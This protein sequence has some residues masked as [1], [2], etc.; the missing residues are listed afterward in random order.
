M[1]S[2]IHNLILISY[3]KNPKFIIVFIQ[4]IYFCSWKYYSMSFFPSFSLENNNLVLVFH[5]PSS[6]EMPC[7]FEFST[8]FRLPQSDNATHPFFQLPVLPTSILHVHHHQLFFPKYNFYQVILFEKSIKA[9]QCLQHKIYLVW[10]DLLNPKLLKIL[11]IFLLFSL[12]PSLCS[13]PGLLSPRHHKIL[14]LLPTIYTYS[15]IS[16]FFHMY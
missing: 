15:S 5:T 12:G 16:Y 2:R 11:T 9:L 13:S 8:S 3:K 6:K 14:V 4:V 1:I 10:K 7:G